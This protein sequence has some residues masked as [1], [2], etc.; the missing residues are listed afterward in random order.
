VISLI[1]YTFHATVIKSAIRTKVLMVSIEEAGILLI[2]NDRRMWSR[3][4]T[5]PLR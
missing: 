4:P 3:P 2:H 1:P 5:F